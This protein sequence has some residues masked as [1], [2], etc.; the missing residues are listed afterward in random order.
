MPTVTTRKK[1]SF[2]LRFC[3]ASASEEDIKK[4]KTYITALRRAY[5]TGNHYDICGDVV[6]K[7]KEIGIDITISHS[8]ELV[9]TRVHTVLEGYNELKQNGTLFTPDT[10]RAIQFVTNLIKTND[11]K[12]IPHLKNLQK[13]GFCIFVPALE[14][15]IRRCIC[16]LLL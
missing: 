3:A 12:I 15:Q 10:E 2:L 7:L 4:S 8:E 11:M 9:K 1:V 14:K 13:C 16:C 6:Q 5:K